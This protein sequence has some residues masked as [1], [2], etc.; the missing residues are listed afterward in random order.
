MSNETLKQCPC[1]NCD[2]WKGCAIAF[3]IHFGDEGCPF[4]CDEYDDWKCRTVEV[5]DE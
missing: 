3:D 1:E 4:K 2:L 5:D